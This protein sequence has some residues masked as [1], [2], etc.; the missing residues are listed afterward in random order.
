MRRESQ[1]FTEPSPNQ[2]LSDDQGK[3]FESGRAGPQTQ[4]LKVGVDLCRNHMGTPAVE[5]GRPG[6]SSGDKKKKKC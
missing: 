3:G 1:D 6:K 2:T 5:P 4:S